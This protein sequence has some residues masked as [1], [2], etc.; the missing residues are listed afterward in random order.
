MCT[1][2]VF[3]DTLVYLNFEGFDPKIFLNDPQN[4]LFTFFNSY[5]GGHCDPLNKKLREN[6]ALN[7]LL[8]LVA[9]FTEDQQF[10]YHTY[11]SS[12]SVENA[13]LIRF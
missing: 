4:V 9:C 3:H 8:F 10:W 13:R 5:E 2:R 7:F 1:Y 6:P 12:E 11:F